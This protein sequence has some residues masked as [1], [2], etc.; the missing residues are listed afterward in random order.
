M[1]LIL[2]E[3]RK[4]ANES[5]SIERRLEE[6]VDALYKLVEVISKQD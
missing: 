4:I 5:D 3:L 6:L 2:Y 1:E